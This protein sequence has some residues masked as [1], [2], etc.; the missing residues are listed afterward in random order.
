MSVTDKEILKSQIR[1]LKETLVI[2]ENQN[3]RKYSITSPEQMWNIMNIKGNKNSPIHPQVK[4]ILH[5]NYLEISEIKKSIQRLENDLNDLNKSNEQELYE[6]P[7]NDIN[8]KN[9]NQNQNQ[10]QVK[11]NKKQNKTNDRSQTKL[12]RFSK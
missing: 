7:K 2:I 5:G 8:S 3:S 1:Q 9:Q 12:N 6:K 10:N 4:Q 11:N